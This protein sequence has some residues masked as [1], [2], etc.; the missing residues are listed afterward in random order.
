MLKGRKVIIAAA[1][2]V[3]LGDDY[4]M[5]EFDHQIAYM[6]TWARM[7]GIV[8]EDFDAVCAAG[9]LTGP[10]GDQAEM[11]RALARAVELAKQV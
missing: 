11:Q 7:C 5:A 10:E 3:A 2:G 4:P 6:R 8:E 1:C 9:T